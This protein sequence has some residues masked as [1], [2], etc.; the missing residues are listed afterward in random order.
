[1]WYLCVCIHGCILTLPHD[2][3]CCTLMRPPATHSHTHTHT[4]IHTHTHT[5]T[6]T[7]REKNNTHTPRP[8]THTHTYTHTHTH[9][10]SQSQR[11]TT[12]TGLPGRY[13]LSSRVKQHV[14]SPQG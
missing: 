7:H 8:H 13:A 2:H 10:Q 14:T 9:T 12:H 11:K 1:M 5:H 3:F 6:H 4:H